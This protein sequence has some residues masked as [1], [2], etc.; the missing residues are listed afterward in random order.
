M[1]VLESPNIM[2]LRADRKSFFGK[3]LQL[4]KGRIPRREYLV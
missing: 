3:S 1:M 4:T 2:E